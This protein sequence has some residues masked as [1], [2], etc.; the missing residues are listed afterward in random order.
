MGWQRRPA[1]LTCFLCCWLKPP[2]DSCWWRQS[3]ASPPSVLIWTHLL[4]CP[5]L[6][7]HPWKIRM[8]AISLQIRTT[9]E[10]RKW[11]KFVDTHSVR[12]LTLKEGLKSWSLLR[13][14]EGVSSCTEASICWGLLR[15]A[16]LGVPVL[17]FGFI[18]FSTERNTLLWK[19][20]KSSGVTTLPP[21]GPSRGISG[22]VRAGGDTLIFCEAPTKLSSSLSVDCEK[23]QG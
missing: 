2:L 20:P 7:V 6:P 11:I 5:I 17:S 4:E 18:S 23:N 8:F 21:W 15:L 22:D 19:R 14:R 10:K 13:K 9:R 12:T 3:V 1:F 16:S